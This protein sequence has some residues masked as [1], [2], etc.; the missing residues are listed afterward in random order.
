M[1]PAVAVVGLG[2]MGSAMALRL[3]ECGLDVLGWDVDACVRARVALDDIPVAASLSDALS[4]RDFIL[5]SLPDSAAVRS[6]WLSPDGLIALADPDSICIDLS[7][8]EPETI[9]QAARAALPRNIDMLDCP[10]SGGPVEARSGTL[11]VMAG[12]AADVIERAQP[13]L[14]CL[15]GALH[16]TGGIG[17]AKVVKIINNMMAMGNLLI[18][19][20]AFSLG[21]TAGVEP[22]C[23]FSVL[24]ECGG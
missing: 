9:R 17:T 16:H 3:R 13:V 22:G 15:G 7:T 6:V 10:V 2:K 23:L 4:K 8:I 11:V 21:M 19:C 14:G 20:E 5:T 1:K 24:A 12:G 18:A